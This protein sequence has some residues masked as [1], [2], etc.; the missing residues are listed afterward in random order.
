LL[1]CAG[2][3]RESLNCLAAWPQGV[4]RTNCIG[5]NVLSLFKRSLSVLTQSACYRNALKSPH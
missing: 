1:S 4:T 5:D 2:E 3:A